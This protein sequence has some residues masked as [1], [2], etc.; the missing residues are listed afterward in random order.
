VILAA[1]PLSA[2]SFATF[3][4]PLGATS[5]GILGGVPFTITSLTSPSLP[6]AN[7]SGSNY[8]ADP[9]S[10]SQQVLQHGSAN[11]WTITFN[12]AIPALEVYAVSWR[13]ASYSYSLTPTIASGL[14]NGSIAGNTLTVDTSGFGNGIITFNNV[15]TLSLNTS[16]TGGG[17]QQLQF[18]VP[19]SNIPEP[20]T[21]LLVAGP[22]AFLLW[23][24]RGGSA[25][26][27]A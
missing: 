10:A 25:N 24:R 4:T 1:N 2:A 19:G 5:T 20:A 14:A 11:D 3:N 7:L 12:S 27:A 23:R 13:P 22:L 18:A 15:T 26:T 16:F 8:S 9:G 17:L 21:A 6:T